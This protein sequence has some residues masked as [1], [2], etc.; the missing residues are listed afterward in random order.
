MNKLAIFF[1]ILLSLLCSWPL[2][3]QSR[4]DE[5]FSF[6]AR[7]SES[8]SFGKD[9]VILNQPNNTQYYAATTASF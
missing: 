7:S 2:L 9:I 3:A 4:Q 1:S 8:P 6:P 5:F